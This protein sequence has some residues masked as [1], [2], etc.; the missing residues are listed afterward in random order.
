MLSS[1]VVN[2]PRRWADYEAAGN[3]PHDRDDDAL[4]ANIARLR[5]SQRMSQAKLADAM[6]AH[7]QTHWHQTTASRVELGK[8]RLTGAEVVAL[9]QILGDEVIAGSELDALLKLAYPAVRDEAARQALA[10]AE[11]ALSGALAVI[12]ELRA[13]YDNEAKEGQA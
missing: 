6:R 9:Q 11:Q 1:L 2:E 7:G 8:Q 5:R 4:A 10:D 3:A 13:I 12:R